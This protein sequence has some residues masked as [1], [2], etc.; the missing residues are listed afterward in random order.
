MVKFFVD[1]M[2]GDHAPDEI[3]K[4]VQKYISEAQDT[5][6]VS[7]CLF[8]VENVVNKYRD[9]FRDNKN[10]EWIVSEG[11]IAMGDKPVESLQNNSK[12]TIQMALDSASNA[13]DAVVISAGNTGGFVASSVLTLGLIDGIRRP[14]IVTALPTANGYAAI[15]DLGANMEPKLSDFLV[16]SKIGKIY[17]QNILGKKQVKVGL[18]NIGEEKG[19]GPKLIQE[20]HQL[21]KNEEENFI[22]NVEGNEIFKGVVDVVVCEGFVGNIML[23]WGEGLFELIKNKIL[24]KFESVLRSNGLSGIF[25]TYLELLK[26]FDYKEYGGALLLGVNGYCIVCHGRSKGDAI[27]NAFRKGHQYVK[28]GILNKI[29][30]FFSSNKNKSSGKQ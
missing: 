13:D 14:A 27:A 17:A 7:V 30:D 24:D 16:Y 6:N 1:L 3:I 11:F 23:K 20:A 10:V 4:G 12:T 22:G 2:G 19:K 18:L 25:T 28:S 21:L 15:L 26:S 9:V 8:A 5:T 29:R